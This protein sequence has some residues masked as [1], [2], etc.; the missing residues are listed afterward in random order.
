GV[1]GSW[2]ELTHEKAMAI[3]ATLGADVAMA[4]DN[5]PP[6][7]AARNLVTAAMERTTR[8]AV[9]CLAAPREAGQQRFGIIQGGPYL[10][11]RR[12]HIDEITALDFDGFALGGFSVGEPHDVM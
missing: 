3:Q 2:G 9:R 4:L 10:D 12:R 6:G 7:D 1:D 11:L 5:C 8:W